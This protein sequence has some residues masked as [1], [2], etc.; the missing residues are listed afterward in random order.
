[1]IK[2]EAFSDDPLRMLRGVRLASDFNFEIEEKTAGYIKN[3]A[4]SLK[5]VSSERIRDELF[6]I[7]RNKRAHYYLLL[8]DEFN[9]LKTVLPEIG[10]YE[11][12]GTGKLS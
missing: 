7:L 11:G 10:G 3:H 9:L 5:T 1:M 6:K 8:L 2:P 4:P 12:N